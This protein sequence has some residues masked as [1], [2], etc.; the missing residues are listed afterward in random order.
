MPR[1]TGS[2]AWRRLA[3]TSFNEAAARCRGKRPR[4]AD[5]RRGVQGCFN[6]A[7]AR[8]RGKRFWIWICLIFFR[9]ASM[10]PRPDAAENTQD[11]YERV[12]GKKLQ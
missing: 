7:A 8:C 1:K 5:T 12:L 2:A 6:E 10:R 9:H 3:R 11:E 4:P